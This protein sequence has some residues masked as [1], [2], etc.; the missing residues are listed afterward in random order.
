MAKILIVDD[1]RELIDVFSMIFEANTFEVRSALDRQSLHRELNGFLPDVVLLDVRLG[2]D[3]GRILCQ[4]IRQNYSS[5]QT[6]VILLSA[7]P[8]LLRNYRSFGADDVLEKP[9]DIN[10]VVNKVNALIRH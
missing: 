8:E 1:S 2:L 4:E 3:D 9:F 10:T 5:Q 7:S 6:S